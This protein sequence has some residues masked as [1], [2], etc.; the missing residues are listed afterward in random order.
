MALPSQRQNMGGCQVTNQ[1]LGLVVAASANV[2]TQTSNTVQDEAPRSTIVMVQI[3]SGVLVLDGKIGSGTI[4]DPSSSPTDTVTLNATALRGFI[5]LD[6]TSSN[7]YW[8]VKL[9][10]TAANVTKFC[11]L[12]LLKKESLEDALSLGFS[13]SAIDSA[14]NGDGSGVFPIGV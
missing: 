2:S 1:D 12:D 6:T 7:L 10:S 13:Q 4:A 9:T 3:A 14:I 8:A 5:K 11:V